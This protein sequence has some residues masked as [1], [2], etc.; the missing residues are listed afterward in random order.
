MGKNTHTWCGSLPCP[1]YQ[2][3]R[4]RAGLPS[5]GHHVEPEVRAGGHFVRT[6]EV[7][8]YVIQIKDPPPMD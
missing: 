5:T 4:G 2:V 6:T 3:Q 1:A 8:L 7:A